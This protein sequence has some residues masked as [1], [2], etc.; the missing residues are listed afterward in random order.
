MR[1][2]M[3]EVIIERPRHGS[4]MGHYR[5]TRRMDA[6]VDVNT[7]PPSASRQARATKAA[8]RADCGRAL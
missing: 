4:R 6:N 1:D 3:F 5:R 8:I 2:D 7:K